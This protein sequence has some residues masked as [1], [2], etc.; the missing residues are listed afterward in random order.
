MLYIARHNII[1]L[2]S[3]NRACKSRTRDLTALSTTHG[4]AYTEKRACTS[5]YNVPVG[6]YRVFTNVSAHR[7]DPMFTYL[8]LT[9]HYHALYIHPHTRTST[10]VFVY[11]KHTYYYCYVLCMTSVHYHNN[12]RINRILR[13]YL[14]IRNS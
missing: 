14:T 3:V 1:C 2:V 10:L 5:L 12:V 8:A 7:P 6:T 4:T 13:T 9:W 11:D